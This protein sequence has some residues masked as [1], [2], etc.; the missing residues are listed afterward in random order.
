FPPSRGQVSVEYLTAAIIVLSLFMIVF[1]FMEQ[2]RIQ[3]SSAQANTLELEVCTKVSSII[4]YM[5]SNPPYS[6]TQFEAALDMNVV[7]GF[8]LVGDIFCP[9]LGTASNTQLYAGL[10]RAFDI[11]GTVLFT[12]DLNYSPFAPAVGSPDS[13]ADQSELIF[14]LIDDQEETWYSEILADDTSY[15]VSPD[16]G[17]YDTDY[18][19]FRF[20]S[21]GLTSANQPTDVRVV[22]KHFESYHVGL[23]GNLSMVQCHN[24]A[25]WVNI[26]SYTPSFTETYY[27]SPNLSGCLSDWNLV[28][29]ARIRMTYEPAGSGHTISIDYARLDVDYT[30]NGIPLDL[31]D[32][33]LDVPPPVDFATD[34]NSTANTFGA[35]QGNDGWDWNRNHYGGILNSSTLFNT[36]PNLDGIITDSNV[37]ATQRLEIRLGGTIQGSPSNPDDNSTLGPIVS[38]AYGIEFDLNADTY[39]LIAGGADANLSFI[40][41]VNTDAVAGNDLDDGEEAWVKIRFGNAGGMAYLGSNLDTGDNDADPTNEVWWMDDPHDTTEFFNQD[42]SPLITGPGTYYIEIGS[43]LADWDA[44]TEGLDIYIDNINLVVGG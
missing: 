41:I 23:G 12:N 16:N 43:A 3:S 38:G 10:V 32:H 27:E 13:N 35:E 36:D 40:Y 18:V 30:Q 44:S 17:T 29:N 26:E 14:L 5:S 22:I 42:V 4:T 31:W 6:E 8:I 15:A 21:A 39:G 25:G 33:S 20:A 28:N 34:V 7:N 2:V 9:Y 1:L 24:G 37:P 19:E 11:N